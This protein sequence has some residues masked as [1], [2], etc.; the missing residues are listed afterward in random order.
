M[1][2]SGPFTRHIPRSFVAMARLKHLGY[3]NV[4]DLLA[5]KFHTSAEV[6]KALNPRRSLDR[7]GTVISV[8]NVGPRPA[9][10]VARVEVDKPEKVV[11]AFGR[12][13]ELVALY[14]ASIGSTEKPAPSG[15]F[16]VRRIARNPDYHD[17]PRFHFKG[18]KTSRRL[19]I[20]PGPKTR[21]VS[22]GS[23]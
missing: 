3:R 17:D 19:T 8:P 9:G 22:S 23:I 10:A 7:A 1:T 16:K 2:T 14:P 11:R 4:T 5:E 20:A 15:V 6:L 21:S 12:N 13:D 18:V